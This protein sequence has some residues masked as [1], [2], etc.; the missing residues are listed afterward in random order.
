MEKNSGEGNIFM[1]YRG[2]KLAV[3]FILRNFAGK[4]KQTLFIKKEKIPWQ[5]SNPSKVYVHRK[6]WWSV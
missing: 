6:N 4:F 1:K 2:K 3:P 5:L